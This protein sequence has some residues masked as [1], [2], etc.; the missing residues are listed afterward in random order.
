VPGKEELSLFFS[1]PTHYIIHISI[2]KVH[3]EKLAVKKKKTEYEEVLLRGVNR[4][5]KRV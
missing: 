1:C 3:A 5:I 2:S 4:C